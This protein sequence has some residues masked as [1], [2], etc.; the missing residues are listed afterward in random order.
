M[1]KATQRSVQGTPRLMSVGRMNGFDRRIVGPGDE[2]SNDDL[3][4][5]AGVSW[6]LGVS[7]DAVRQL[8]H[9]PDFP[10]PERLS[11]TALWAESAILAWREVWDSELETPADGQRGF[12]GAA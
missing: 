9:R 10:R 3:I 2:R 12:G 6:L 1:N 4:A 5:V 7:P 8:C 11:P